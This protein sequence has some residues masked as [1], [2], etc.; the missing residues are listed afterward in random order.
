MLWLE[1]KARLISVDTPLHV[2]LCTFLNVIFDN[3]QFSRLLNDFSILL[4]NCSK[5]KWY[6]SYN[7]FTHRRWIFDAIQSQP[8]AKKNYPQRIL[9][10]CALYTNTLLARAY[11]N[12]RIL[13]DCASNRSVCSNCFSPDG[14]APSYTQKRAHNWQRDLYAVSNTRIVPANCGQHKRKEP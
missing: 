6:N 13:R 7:L 12:N 8:L 5:Y 4:I 9:L 11:A 2:V 14:G 3:E 1:N 10:L